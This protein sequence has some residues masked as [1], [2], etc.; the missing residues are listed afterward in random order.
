MEIDILV[1]SPHPDDGEIGCGGLLLLLKKKGYKTGILHMTR[2]ELGTGGN[3]LIRSAE[4]EAAGEILKLDFLEVGGFEDCKIEDNFKNRR[5]MSGYIRRLRPKVVILPYWESD[6]PG[7]HIG[8]TDH[9]NTGLIG[10]H[11]VNLARLRKIESEE[12]AH[13]VDRVFYYLYPQGMRADFVVDITEV[14]VDWIRVL[15]CYRS[16]MFGE[17]AMGTGFFKKVIAESKVMGF[18]I[19]ARY[20]QGFLSPIPLRVQDPLLL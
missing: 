3:E 19:G 4:M 2:G 13:R 15:R 14:S 12:E 10:S 6:P 17:N 1:L 7:R 8:H 5:I 16:Q 20:G 9:M 18:E 11:G